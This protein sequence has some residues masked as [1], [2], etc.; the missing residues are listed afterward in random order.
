MTSAIRRTEEQWARHAQHIAASMCFVCKCF[1][2]STISRP[3][4]LEM[5]RG[6][7]DGLC[8][9]VFADFERDF[10]SQARKQ[11]DPYW[12]VHCKKD[13]PEHAWE[14][15]SATVWICPKG[16]KPRHTPVCTKDD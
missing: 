16:H 15:P 9:Q 14:R 13:W 2:Q 4:I 6:Y 10:P 1:E 3:R 8:D 12:C 11:G 7:R 5:L